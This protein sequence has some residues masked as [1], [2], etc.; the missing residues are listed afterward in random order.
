MIWKPHV[1]V[2]AVI[3]KDSRFLMVEETTPD[4]IKFNQPAG[5]LE[6]GESLLDAVRREVLEETAWV[7]EP[8]AIISV[9]LWRKSPEAPSFLRFC[10]SGQTLSHQAERQLDEGII[11]AHWLSYEEVLAKREVLR[12]PLVITC[13]EAFMKNQVHPLSMLQAL[14]DTHE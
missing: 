13:I 12:S 6:P 11:A 14:L 10:F 5:H 2:A 7:F 9:Q 8:D 4:G 1:T 3:E